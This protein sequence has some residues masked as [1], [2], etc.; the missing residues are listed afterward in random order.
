MFRLGRATTLQ[1]LAEMSSTDVIIPY[2]AS[3]S[4]AQCLDPCRFLVIP[5]NPVALRPIHE[6]YIQNM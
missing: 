1:L 2:G 5:G 4:H 6:I 3:T